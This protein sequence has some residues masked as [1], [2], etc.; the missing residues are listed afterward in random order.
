[1]ANGKK[2]AGIVL[3][4]IGLIISIGSGIFLG[5]FILAASAYGSLMGAYIAA[6]F[7]AFLMFLIPTIFGAVLFI[8]G[9]ILLL[10][11]RKS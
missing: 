2:I 9:L 11:S 5:F 6:Y 3:L 8:I 1:M 10:L 4:V 7:P